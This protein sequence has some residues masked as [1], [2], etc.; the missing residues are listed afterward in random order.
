[1]T[2]ELFTARRRAHPAIALTATLGALLTVV[3]LSF[4]I[5]P[6]G[7]G[8][9]PLISAV[10]GDEPGRLRSLVFEVRLP[11]A[12][13]AVL[14]GT[15]LA[16]AGLLA[17]ALTRNPLASPQT[18]GINAG[19]A[20]AIV[21]ATIAY[22]NL[23]VFGTG[24]AFAGALVVGAIM[25]ALSATSSV[26]VVGLALAGMTMQIVLSALVQAI[27]IM[28]NSTQDLVFWLAGSIAGAQ[29]EDVAVLAPAAFIGVCAAFLGRRSF[30]LLSL[31]PATA[32]SLG[33]HS[34]RVSGIAAIIVVVLAASAVAVA[35]PIGF[36]GLIVPHIARGM[37]G[38]RFAT[39]LV[40]CTVLGPLLLL[41]ADVLARLVAFPTEIP[42][43]IVTA[44]LGAPTFLFLAVRARRVRTG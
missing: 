26:S 36:V 40:A 15:A 38:A 17:Q 1:M 5:G 2:T 31:D 9:E 30:A 25:W 24:A 35:G 41:S 10:V 12:V 18:F 8:W 13:L 20:V 11:R 21:T 22:P 16:V 23:G 37:V 43:G 44:L 3:L 29:W 7:I 33:Q 34:A 42:A 28:N 14:V 4:G 39:Q 27:L 19:A 32:G 6:T